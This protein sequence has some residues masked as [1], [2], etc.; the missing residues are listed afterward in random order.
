MQ[1]ESIPL[2]KSQRKAARAKAKAERKSARDRKRKLSKTPEGRAVLAAEKQ[3]RR[4]A[5]KQAVEDI[6]QG[7]CQKWEIWQQDYPTEAIALA[8]LI[9]Y[10][11]RLIKRYPQTKSDRNVTQQR[12][13]GMGYSVKDLWIV[14]NRFAITEASI[15]KHER[16]TFTDWA[17]LYDFR[18]M[19]GEWQDED[20]F[21]HQVDF[22]LFAYTLDIDGVIYRF[23]SHQEVLVDGL[24]AKLDPASNGRAMAL[25]DEEMGPSLLDA[26]RMAALKTGCPICF[27]DHI[28]FWEWSP[29]QSEVKLP[30]F[31]G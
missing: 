7:Y 21:A 27:L 6:K 9:R 22:K 14:N 31:Y 13:V 30:V 1:A 5:R 26:I 17:A 10:I 16:R 15:S 24:E 4:V 20:D 11:N 23:H 12:L 19:T 3:A 2:T 25:Q 8:E 18:R 28:E 29:R